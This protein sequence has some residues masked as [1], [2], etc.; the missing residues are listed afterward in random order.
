MPWRYN[1]IVSVGGKEVQVPT[2]Y[3]I[4]IFGPRGMTHNVRVFAL[5]YTPKVV[6]TT[7]PSPQE[8]E[9][10]CIPTTPIET[11]DS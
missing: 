2:T 11:P 8:G 1:V 4:N 7:V 10:V 5:K 9:F 6:R 3:V